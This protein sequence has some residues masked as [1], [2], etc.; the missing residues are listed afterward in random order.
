MPCL[1]Q[2][3][4]HFY[5]IAYKEVMHHVDRFSQKLL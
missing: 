5:G 4:Y 2:Y 3:E 1:K